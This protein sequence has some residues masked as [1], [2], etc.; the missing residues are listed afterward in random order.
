MTRRDAD[1][2]T[3]IGTHADRTALPLAGQNV[4][5]TRPAHQAD[6]LCRQLAELGAKPVRFPTLSINPVAES[7]GGYPSLK[8][9]FL[10]LDQYQAVIFVSANAVRLAHDWIDQYWPQL[11]L[12]ID[13]LA[14]GAA[15]SNAMQQY[16]LPTASIQSDSS[17][18]D[19]EALLQHPQLQQLTHQKILICRGQGGRELLRDSLQQRGAQVDYAELYRREIPVYSQ[20]EI[21]SIIYKSAISAMLISSGEALINLAAL[22]HEAATGVSALSETPL[23]VPSQRVAELAAEYQFKQVRVAANATDDAMLAALDL[24]GC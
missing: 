12:S 20:A 11:P 8:N 1:A 9:C 18:M 19:S 3:G 6:R 2:E 5:V 23:V 17:S 21:E 15:T 4:L 16:G 24:A 14:V 10:N 7:D 13:W 22:T